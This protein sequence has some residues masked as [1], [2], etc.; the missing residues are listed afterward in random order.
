MYRTL[1]KFCKGKGWQVECEYKFHKIRK[2]RIDFC[3]F[4]KKVKPV[5]AFEYEGIF[6]KKSRHTTVK[7][8]TGDTDKYNEIQKTGMKLFR[9]TALNYKQL[10]SDLASL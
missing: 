1:I 5:A 4:D 6:S 7:G 10:E 9:Y 8:F 3:L 2:W